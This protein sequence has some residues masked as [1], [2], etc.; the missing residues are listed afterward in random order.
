MRT[1]VDL[2]PLAVIV[3]LI[4]GGTLAGIVGALVAVPT[5]ALCA[6]LIDEYLVQRPERATSAARS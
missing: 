6:V 5:A 2:P 1:T 4:I 3:S